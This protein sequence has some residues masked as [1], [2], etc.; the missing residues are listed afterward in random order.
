MQLRAQGQP[1]GPPT[2]AVLTRL[3]SFTPTRGLVFGNYGEC[4]SD[5]VS[6]LDHCADRLA[7]A[8]WRLLGSRSKE[9]AKGLHLGRLRQQLGLFVTREFARCRLRRAP[10]VG[11]DRAALAPRRGRAVRAG[12]R[13]PTAG[14]GFRL[15]DFAGLQ[16]R[17]A[18]PA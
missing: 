14:A 13:A 9:E 2:S 8:S 16:A 3:Q 11:C 10:Y 5:V 4:S 15:A 17:L 7:A 12:N 6:L 1:P 18:P